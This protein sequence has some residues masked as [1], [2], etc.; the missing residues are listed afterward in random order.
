MHGTYAWWHTSRRLRVQR[1]RVGKLRWSCVPR[2]QTAREIVCGS[3]ACCDSNVVLLKGGAPLGPI[4][5]L[6]TLLPP[7]AATSCGHQLS[8]PAPAS[9]PSTLVA[10]CL[11]CSPVH[12]FGRCVPG[13][14]AAPAPHMP[15][16]AGQG[17]TLRLP[18]ASPLHVAARRQ[19]SDQA[20]R[21]LP[22]ASPLE[23]LSGQVPAVR[24]HINWFMRHGKDM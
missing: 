18:L 20:R 24:G 10:S 12:P 17:C 8:V 15:A 3:G 19:G 1:N 13:N 23:S 4:T 22:A 2:S 7:A 9:A 5:L 11:T 16:V 21:C 6:V 14:T